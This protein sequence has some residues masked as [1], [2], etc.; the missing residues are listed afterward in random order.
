M[1]D[2]PAVIDALRDVFERTAQ[3]KT[4]ARFTIG[5]L[6]GKPVELIY[7]PTGRPYFHPEGTFYG[8]G[9]IV[10][11][12]QPPGALVA[13]GVH[14]MHM[15]SPA[16]ES[17]SGGTIDPYCFNFHKSSSEPF[18]LRQIAAGEW[19]SSLWMDAPT[20]TVLRLEDSVR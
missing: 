10:I 17:S 4:C 20:T 18:V 5:A 11:P 7:T 1:N 6:N 16:P 12:D 14:N 3:R 2:P 13:Y 19:T 15:L 8:R 9:L